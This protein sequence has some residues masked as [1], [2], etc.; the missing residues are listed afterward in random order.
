MNCSHL[1][2]HL[3]SGQLW[4]LVVGLLFTRL[5]LQAQNDGMNLQQA[6][7]YA[8]ANHPD[9]QDAQLKIQDADIRIKENL[10]TGIPQLTASGQYQRYFE[11]PV[12]PLPPEFTGGGEP[13][14]VSFVLKNN[15]TGSLN[16]DAMIFD[17]S[18][19]VGLRAARASRSYAQLELNERRRQV[20]NQVRDAYLP[21]LLVDENL[22]QLDKNIANLEKLFGETKATYEQGFI[23]QLDVDRLE[24]SLANLRTERENLSRQYDMAVEVLRFTLNYPPNEPLVVAENLDQLLVMEDDN[25]LLAQVDYNRRPEISLLDQAIALNGMNVE[26]NK[27]RRLPSLRG[28]GGYQYQYQGNDFST[29]FWAPT[30]FLGLSLSVPLYDGGYKKAL[31]QRAQIAQDQVIIQRSTVKRGIDLEVSNARKAYQNAQDRLADRERNLMLAQRIYD[32]T[33]IKYSEGVGSS[34]EV[35]Q[36]EIDF[37]AA[38]TNRLQAVYDLLQAKVALEEALGIK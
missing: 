22:T 10:A 37:Y 5:G 35:S 7:D 14:E 4:L 8:L 34:L 6:I 36:A 29:G 24:L 28:F 33:K 21:L 26:L 9:I 32:T 12:V 3:R 31:V 11:V 38:Q 20:R 17:A 25:A 27:S 1:F 19:F 15:L 16:L 30:G 18:Y 13:Q 23:E 2:H